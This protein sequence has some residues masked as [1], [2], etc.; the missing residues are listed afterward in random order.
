MTVL[1][2]IAIFSACTKESTTP[3]VTTPTPLTRSQVLAKYTWQLDEVWTNVNATGTN[4]HYVRNGVNTTG[5]SYEKMRLTFKVDS[6]GS[7]TDETGVYHA[8][9]WKFTSADQ[10]NLL[11]NVGAP[12]PIS[13][14]WTM[15]EI[16]DSTITA[17][18]PVGTNGLVSARYVTMDAK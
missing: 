15:L 1:L 9:T 14:T 7:Y 12:Y 3:P 5:V 13:F 8:T 18:S 6:T 11:L 4:K 10:H 2:T 16:S 17:L